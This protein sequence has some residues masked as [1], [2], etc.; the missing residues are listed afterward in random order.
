M[1]DAGAV[2]FRGMAELDKQLTYL[3]TRCAARDSTALAA[4]YQSASPI[5]FGTLVRILRRRAV[6]EEAL[7][8]VFIS[9][10]ERAGQF[11]PERGNALAWMLAIAR[12]RA[13]DLIRREKAVPLAVLEAAEDVSD[14]PESV[15]WLSSDAILERCLNL[16]SEPQRNCI[17]LAFVDGRSHDEIAQR[18]GNPLGTIKSWIRR[19]LQS[20]RQC[21]EQ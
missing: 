13:I 16:L 9:V 6:A 8:D 12:Y 11:Q 17:V 19:G 15:P 2:H 3:L 7:Q 10:W 1:K 4:L 14:E 20:L 5:L 18:T 21:I